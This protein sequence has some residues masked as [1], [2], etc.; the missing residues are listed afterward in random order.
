MSRSMRL[1]LLQRSFSDHIKSST[2][3]AL[4]I[5]SK[6]SRENRLAGEWRTTGVCLSSHVLAVI[7]NMFIGI[8]CLLD[9]KL[10]LFLRIWMQNYVVIP[11]DRRPYWR[12]GFL[13]QINTTIY[14]KVCGCLSKKEKKEKIT[15][16]FIISLR[17]S[18]AFTKAPSSRPSCFS[19]KWWDAVLAHP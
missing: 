3:K 5:L 9:L 6:P 10:S 17:F 12:Q 1:L 19:Q 7:K 18:C 13:R 15:A 4:D 8:S 14:F 2:T 16:W 11:S